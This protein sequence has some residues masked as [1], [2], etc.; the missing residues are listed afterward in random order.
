MDEDDDENDEHIWAD[1]S[2][3]NEDLL[4]GPVKCLFCNHILNSAKQVFGHS[5]S[6]HNFCVPAFCAKWSL[7][8]LG[9]IKLINFI[10]IQVKLR[11]NTSTTSFHITNI[12]VLWYLSR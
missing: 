2:D 3:E 7:D 10:R 6:D 9:Y 12:V 1:S 5:Q 8:C 11:C 4:L